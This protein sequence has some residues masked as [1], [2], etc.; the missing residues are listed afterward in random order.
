MNTQLTLV[1]FEEARKAQ[2]IIPPV[3]SNSFFS[4]GQGRINLFTVRDAVDNYR[5]DIFTDQEK[6]Y[7]G[8]GNFTISGDTDNKDFPYRNMAIIQNTSLGINQSL[9]IIKG[10]LNIYGTLELLPNSKLSIENGGKVILHP[11]SILIVNDGTDFSIADADPSD[12]S[13]IIYGRI[14]IHVSRLDFILGI[15]N[16]VLDSAAVLNVSG[17]EQSDRVYSLTD[18]DTELR[19][20]FINV[21]TQGEKNLPN[22]NRVGHIWRD[23]SP[24]EPSQVVGMRTHFGH[25][26]LGDVRL[27]ILG[28]PEHT[29]PQMQIVSD[30]TI[31]RNSTLHITETFEEFNYLRPELYL[32]VIIGNTKTPAECIVQ[33]GIIVSGSTASIVV[34]RG[35]TLTI[36]DGGVIHLI[37]NGTIRST[38]N[39][40]KEVL[41]IHGTLV[42]EC[43]SQIKSFESGNIVFGPKG[44]IVVLNDS[45]DEKRLLFTTPNGILESDLYRLFRDRIDHIEYHIPHNAGIGIDQHFESYSRDMRNWFGDRRFEK[46]IHDG[47]LVWHEGAFIEL[48][49]HTTP[50]VSENT[51]LLEASRIFKSF[52]WLDKDRLQDVANRLRYAGCG[53]ILFRFMVGN[54]VKELTLVLESISMRSITNNPVTERFSLSTDN[55]GTLFIRNNI[56]NT[57][58]RHILHPLSRKFE[59]PET[60]NLEF[61][62]S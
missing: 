31:R 28:M 25:F 49:D 15:K 52:G 29:H 46:A 24:S 6:V 32:G 23:G 36:E 14:D 5:F 35:A 60:H 43:I 2:N 11:S 57:D 45:T 34:D 39:G 54:M 12:P 21:N 41:F 9:T 44:K 10:E 33:G 19:E 1:Q 62:L 4:V 30:I 58:L 8:P 3:G 37:D 47:I 18:Y 27:A 20:R 17:I 53:N 59:I 22:G 16:L 40:D 56:R 38:H 55:D 13:V 61:T 26:P 51:T 48:Y 42:I 7:T 50:W